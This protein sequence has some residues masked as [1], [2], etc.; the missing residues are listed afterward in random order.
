MNRLFPFLCI[1]LLSVL[2][3]KAQLSEKGDEQGFEIPTTTD[4][5]EDMQAIKEARDHWWPQSMK[6]KDERT[7]W[8]KE[9]RFGCFIHWGVYSTAAGYWKGK[10]VS[11]YSEHL[12]RKER[13]PLDEYKKTLVYSFNPV[14]FDADEWMKT[15]VRA[16][17][18]YFIITAK[19]HDG[20]AMFPSEAYPYDI[21]LTSFHR[22][23][24]KELREAARKYGVK[25][26]FYYSHAFDW[27]HP[28]A[29]G[30]D[31]EYRHPGGDQRLGGINWWNSEYH[32]YLA[33][34]D[35]YVKEKSIPQILEL[36]HNYQPDILWFDTPGKLP[37]YQNIRILKTIREADPNQQ[38]VVNGRLAR[39]GKMNLGDYVNTGDRAAFFFPQQG[40]WESIPTTNE[41]YGYSA[42]DTK[43]KS[44]KHFVRLI[45][46]AVSKGGNILMNVGPM[47]NGKWDQRD[48]DIFLGIGNWMK[49]NGN[50]IYGAGRTD[51]PIQQWGVL[52]A[53][54]DT[55]YAH[56]H[57]WPKD[58][59]ITIGGLRSNIR[60]AWM[61]SEQQQKE[62]RW[63][64]INK[65]DCQLLLSGP[66]PDTLSTVV[67]FTIDKKT[68]AC[69]DRLL[70]AHTDNILYTFDATLTGKGLGYGD[71]KV[72]RNY[73]K[74]WKD[75]SQQMDWS[76]RLN[77]KATYT[78][79]LDYNTVKAEDQ[80]TVMVTIDNQ[81]F[82]VS[83]QGF[84]ERQG[85]NRLKVGVIH[86]KKGLHHCTLQG[87]EYKGE[88]YMCP[89]AILLNNKL[90]NKDR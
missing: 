23:P 68:D 27:E 29:P 87:K 49:K 45:E 43:R 83:Y 58:G 32:H 60:K 77:E 65:D 12:M 48:V 64:R 80:G 25:F 78:L 4:L 75:N 14:L 28:C 69:P 37:L 1:L 74:N 76:F 19:H 26:G 8:Y 35:K 30:N 53:K 84:T 11:G 3:I 81:S 50:S 22:D 72:N 41:S 71:G 10:P 13:I 55:L 31:W 39:F 62:V 47:G 61:L 90:N 16:G 17:M 38:I 51:L 15:A 86:L 40:L 57:Q 54:Y 66:M 9:A 33:E 7:A 46:S 79:Y 59:R 34:A 36:I 6:N 42:S 70:N 24:M 89:I 18:K 2:P 52:T 88:Q 5:P 56:I 82:E 85:T 67:A 44:V 20:F 73:V 63:K 21:R